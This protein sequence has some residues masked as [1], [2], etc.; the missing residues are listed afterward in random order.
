MDE[1]GHALQGRLEFCERNVKTLEQGVKGLLKN[2]EEGWQATLNLSQKI[3]DTAAQEH[4]IDLQEDLIAIAECTKQLAEERRLIMCERAEERVV[5]TLAF[6]QERVLHPTKLLLKD[7]ERAMR[8]YKNMERKLTYAGERTVLGLLNLEETEDMKRQK[9]AN[10][11]ECAAHTDDVV[12]SNFRCFEKSRVVELKA[13]LEE[14][15]RAEMLYHCR[16]LELLEPLCVSMRRLDP[17]RAMAS[18]AQELDELNDKGEQD[19]EAV[20]KLRMG[21]TR[22]AF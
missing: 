8:K 5:S 21:A 10:Y 12:D 20:A 6:I 16:A 22:R 18:I 2:H 15:L 13:M 3:R 7:R 17:D 1:K 14:A 9:L 11:G 4:F 19:R